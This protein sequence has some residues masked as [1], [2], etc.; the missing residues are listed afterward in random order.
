MV[1]PSTVSVL[2][3]LLRRRVLSASRMMARGFMGAEFQLR[4]WREAGAREQIAATLD[5]GGGES[6]IFALRDGG[7]PK[8]V[9]AGAEARAAELQFRGAGQEFR[10]MTVKFV[11]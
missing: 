11:G 7:L 9:F 3:S 5:R 4:T 2:R 8:T 10:G 1:T 6:G